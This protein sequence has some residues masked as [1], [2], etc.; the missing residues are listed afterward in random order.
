MFVQHSTSNYPA[1]E[2]YVRHARLC[3]LA[4]FQLNPVSEV[5]RT[6]DEVVNVVHGHMVVNEEEEGAEPHQ[7]NVLSNPPRIII[8]CILHT[9]TPTT[10]LCFI[11]STLKQI[12][13]YLCHWSDQ[14]SQPHNN[15][16]ECVWPTLNSATSENSKNWIN[17][18]T[19]VSE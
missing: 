7:N 14:Q 16:D 13:K 9:H 2:S 15:E 4:T 19:A 17:L 6:L 5:T 12:L 8:Q 10:R 11:S 18:T 3:R 1:V